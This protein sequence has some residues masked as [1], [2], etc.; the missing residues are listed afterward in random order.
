MGIKIT[1]ENTGQR[2]DK[3]LQEKLE[4]FSR[5][6]I[7]KMIKG[8]T[9]TVNKKSVNKHYA[10]QDGDIISIDQSL[11]SNELDKNIEINIIGEENKFLVIEKPANLLV[12]ATT[13]NEKNT[14]VNWLLKQYPDI[15][16]VGEE[17]DRPG[18]VHR[19]DKEVSG[20]MIIAKTQAMYDHL[21]KQFQ[22]REIKKEYTALVFGEPSL[23]EIT[24][25][26]PLSRSNLTGRISAHAKGEEGKQAITEVDVT[27]RYKNYTL[28]KI[29]P[30]TG[31]TNQIRVHLKAI[32][33]PIVGDKLYRIKRYT[34][35]HNVNRV[36]LHADKIAFKDLKGEVQEFS[37][38]IPE[39]FNEII[40]K[41]NA[42]KK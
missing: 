41:I 34:S 6:Q 10:I 37:S 1:S 24:I 21:K 31:R 35:K 9:I 42:K 30:K 17:P 26:F 7:Q 20:I 16:E 19:L 32:G 3:F 36:L 22:N 15:V 2:I 14:V 40:N 39:I 5:T 33:H 27:A 4:G 28:L 11:K 29:Q 13:K 23:D 8:E 25:D 18:I 38:S 12:H